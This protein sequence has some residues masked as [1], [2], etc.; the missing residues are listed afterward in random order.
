MAPRKKIEKKVD[1]AEDLTSVIEDAPVIDE[2]VFVV[3]EGGPPT[4]KPIGCPNYSH[5]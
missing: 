3:L 5:L 2:P 1:E 4:L